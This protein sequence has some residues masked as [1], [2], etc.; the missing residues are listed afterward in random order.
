MHES[1][2]LVDDNSLMLESVAAALEAEGYRVW[3]AA[4]GHCALELAR[5]VKLDAVVTDLQMPGMDGVC[6]LEHLEEV[7]PNGL[8]MVVYSAAPEQASRIIKH[9]P[10]VRSVLKAVEHAALLTTLHSVLR[11]AE[12]G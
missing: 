6:L 12:V 5:Q 11:S 3:A 9:I 2:L 4:S 7:R 10:R 8:Q 1:V